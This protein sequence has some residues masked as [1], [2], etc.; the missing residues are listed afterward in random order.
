VKGLETFDR[1]R[2]GWMQRISLFTH[3]EEGYKTTRCRRDT[4]S[5]SNITKYAIYTET[6]L[7]YQELDVSC[8]KL[9]LLPQDRCRGHEPRRCR[10]NM[11]HARQ[12]RPVSRFVLRVKGLGAFK[13]VPSSLGI[14]KRESGWQPPRRKSTRQ[15][16]AALEAKMGVL[17]QELDM[18]YNR[19]EL[20]P[21][22]FGNL[23][24]LQY[25][26]LN[27]NLLRALPEYAL[28]SSVLLLIHRPY[29]RQYRRDIG[30]FLQSSRD[31]REIRRSGEACDEAAVPQPQ[32]QPSPRI[33]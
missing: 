1:L 26:N 6:K 27:A 21:Q 20:L 28:L 2:V 8:N 15:I 7:F 33:P 22:E 23:M 18:S 11:A 30:G 32:R 13:A 29:R 24:K 17:H 10:A 19:L 4:Y 16:T 3:Q 25:L 31:R 14:G 12:S 9:E 5:E